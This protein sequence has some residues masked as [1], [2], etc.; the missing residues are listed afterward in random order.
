MFIRLAASLLALL[1]GGV[2][3][4]SGPV[5]PQFSPTAPSS[6]RMRIGTVQASPAPQADYVWVQVD[7][8]VV[9]AAY[10]TNYVPIPGDEVV[11]TQD[12]TDWFVLG[13]RS[14]RA[15]NLAVNGDFA[16]HPQ[17]TISSSLPAY[18]WGQAQVSGAPTIAFVGLRAADSTLVFKLA[19]SPPSAAASDSYIYSAAFPVTPG[20]TLYIDVAGQVFG[21]GG[22]TSTATIRACWFADGQD[23]AFPA[24]L[25][26]TVIDT[27]ATTT[28]LT[29]W[30]TGSTVVPVGAMYARLAGRLVY[31]GGGGSG[32]ALDFNRAEAHQ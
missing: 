3:V 18:M 17:P 2:L 15:G 11:I 4:A 9:Q 5:N 30:S 31:A 16:V 24:A 22:I 29:F 14:G 6:A 7:G 23:T 32:G 21:S 19:T 25:G 13:G 12:G 10:F 26:E 27:Q 28:S 8:A 1:L 20:T